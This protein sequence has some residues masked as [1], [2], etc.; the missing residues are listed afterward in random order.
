MGNWWETAP[1]ARTVP[2]L[3]LP[4]VAMATL[5]G[6]TTTKG[7]SAMKDHSRKTTTTAGEHARPAPSAAP[8]GSDSGKLV[9]RAQ[10]ARLLGKGY[11]TVK[12]W[13]GS[14]LHPVRDASGT[15]WFREEDVRALARRLKQRE[16]VDDPTE[17]YDGAT[18]A[19]VFRMLD[20]GKPI[21]DAIVALE[22]HPA[23]AR[24]IAAEWA[25]LRGGF[26]IGAKAL[27]RIDR[28]S[29][30]HVEESLRTEADLVSAL[31][32][33][34]AEECEICERRSPRVC[35]TCVMQRRGEFLALV[36]AD[37]AARNARAA[38]RGERSR[39]QDAHARAAASARLRTEPA[40]EITMR[41]PSG[42]APSVVDEST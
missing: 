10:A 32:T 26:F 21:A 4:S 9:T 8:I 41:P 37:D 24:A 17:N 36:K 33:I 14:E 22:V 16:I 40:E 6:L 20:E 25:D 28:I 2:A 19:R 23:V 7:L 34:S 11:N 1:A 12:R 29:I 13:E 39:L 35:L 30:M 31:E 3:L 42:R 15:H 18:A 38:K 27:A 5:P